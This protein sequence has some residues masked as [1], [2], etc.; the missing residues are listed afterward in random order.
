MI[1]GVHARAA[2]LPAHVLLGTDRIFTAPYV[3]LIK[4]RRVG[5]LSHQAS[6]NSSGVHLVDLL[7]ARSDVKVK[8]LFAPEHGFRIDQDDPLPDSK[9][10]KTGLTVY[11]LYGP[12]RCNDH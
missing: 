8:A 6:V 11:S 4:N 7:T 10:S 5:V 9:D 3:D 1:L 12:R 2:N